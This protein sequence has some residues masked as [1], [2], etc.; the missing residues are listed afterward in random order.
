MLQSGRA[1]SAPELSGSSARTPNRSSPLAIA[2]VRQQRD[3]VFAGRG[4]VNGADLTPFFCGSLPVATADHTASADVGWSVASCITAPASTMRPKFGRRPSAVARAMKSSDAP[5]IARISTLAARSGG[6]VSRTASIGRASSVG[7]TAAPLNTSGVATETAAR[8][9]GTRP[10]TS[11]AK[12]R[13]SIGRTRPAGT[14]PTTPPARA[15]PG[16]SPKPSRARAP[17]ERRE[18]R[19]HQRRAG[20]RR[21]RAQPRQHADAEPRRR[22]QLARQQLPR[23]QQHVEH[24]GQCTT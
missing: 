17:G 9:P 13:R 4:P 3:R 12:G 15:L 14:A 5:S 22:E 19:P 7:S 24:H 11:A 23:H 21:Q 2:E 18:V 1:R 6:G 8:R 10:T 20:R 16:S